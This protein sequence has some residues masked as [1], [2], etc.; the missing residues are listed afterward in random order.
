[1]IIGIPK[2][3]KNNENRVGIV[4]AGVRTLVENGHTV[5]V[6]TEA[7][8]G[9]GITDS[10]YAEAGAEIVSISKVWDANMIIK[11]KEPLEEEFKYIKKDQIIFTYLHLAAN[12]KLTDFL[13]KS[14]AI[15]VAYETM[16]GT[17]NDLPLLT[18]MSEVA[19]RMS[20][21]IGAHFLEKNNGGSGVLLGGISGVLPGRVTIIGGGIVGYNAAKTAVGLGA[22]VTLLDINPNRLRELDNIFNGRVRLLISNSTNISEAVAQADLVVGAVLIPGDV[23]PKIVKEEYIKKMKPGSVVIDIPI[24]QGGIFETSEKITSH[25]SPIFVKHGVIHYTVPN[26]PG[27]VAKT[28]TFALTNSTIPYALEIANRGIVAAALE[29]K[30]IKT[31][32]NIFKNNITLEVVAKAFKEEFIDFVD[33][34]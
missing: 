5:F 12:K 6:Q 28:A 7:G 4:P 18:P 26:M 33:L 20:V 30:T 31:G 11:V 16:V 10:E 3:I 9:S 13:K 29:N 8:L 27:A 34:I 24:D 17:K 2:E 19:G 21:Q 15:G 22:E 23:A 14:G 25:E 1:M 32:I